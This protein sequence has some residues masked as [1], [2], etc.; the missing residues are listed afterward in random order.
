MYVIAFFIT[1]IL[2]SAILYI[3]IKVAESVDNH[4]GSTSKSDF[5][6]SP[7]P[8]IGMCRHSA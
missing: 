8:Y 7:N 2:F 3:G 4:K 1:V 6:I 5:V